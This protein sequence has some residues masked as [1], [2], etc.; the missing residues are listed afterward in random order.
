MRAFL[1]LANG[2]AVILDEVGLEVSN[3]ADVGAATLKSLSIEMAAQDG[4]G[5]RLN[6]VNRPG[7]LLF[8]TRLGQLRVG[9]ALWAA[10]LAA[11]SQGLRRPLWTFSTTEPAL[12]GISPSE[13]FAPGVDC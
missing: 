7:A 11:R 3:L 10:I 12:A 8:S 5:W 4:A 1:R 2:T 13:C 6:L 9:G